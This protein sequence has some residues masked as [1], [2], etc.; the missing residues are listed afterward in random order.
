VLGC[1]DARSLCSLAQASRGCRALAADPIAWQTLL[2]RRYGAVEWALPP[3]AL[4]PRPG[5]TWRELYFELGRDESPRCWGK[6]AARA[7]SDR[8]S[9]WLLI[10]RTVYDVTGFMD[11][12]PGQAA[13]LLLFGGAD[14]TEAFSEVA[15]SRQ[16]TALMK[17]LAVRTLS[18]PREGQPAC[19]LPPHLYTKWEAAAGS[20]PGG[21]AVAL[22]S[23]LAAGPGHIASTVASTSSRV[24]SGISAMK[25]SMPDAVADSIAASIFATVGRSGFRASERL[26]RLI[27]D[28]W[29]ATHHAHGEQAGPLRG[30]SGSI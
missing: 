20:P 14:A 3:G 30:R 26:A 8:S 23:F 29:R 15:H 2:R 12:H 1:L 22:K 17:E 5:E 28:R 27:A 6:L 7:H 13:S 16:A 11:R 18:I 25:N 19:L 24:T 4:R 10:D 21:R 9:C